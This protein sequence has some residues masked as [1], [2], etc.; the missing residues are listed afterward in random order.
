MV[1]GCS[2]AQNEPSTT[3]APASD[4]SADAGS[5]ESEA[6]A[7]APAPAAETTTPAPSE[8]EVN[9]SPAPQ[10]QEPDNAIPIPG[11]SE[12]AYL[13]G[14]TSAGAPVYLADS[15][16][17]DCRPDGGCIS[18][19]FL[20]VDTNGAVK[21]GQAI[22]RCGL[23]T[24]SEVVLDGD[25]VA[26]EG[27]VGEGMAE[28]LNTACQSW[29]PGEPG[30][31]V[32]SVPEGL[33]AGMSYSAVRDRLGAA[34]W[35]AKTTGMEAYTSLE[36]Q[37]YDKGYTEVL[38]CSGAGQCRFEFDYYLDG[39]LPEGEALVVITRFADDDPF[40]ENDPVLDSVSI[41]G[42]FANDL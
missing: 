40:F 7:T 36:Q 14:K 21:Q 25:L 30:A 26:Y 4:A 1:V 5:L 13:M 23:F 10:S 27:L 20:Q 29:R 18:I 32:P 15:R 33:S 22:G 6:A 39:Q 8:P 35:F 42:S 31:G 38:G 17:F 11:S 12:L 19:E 37:M 2:A 28:L 16:P 3:I 24:L 9:S 41:Q 34:G